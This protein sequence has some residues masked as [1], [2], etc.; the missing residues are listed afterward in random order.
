MAS[1]TSNSRT[2]RAKKTP[3]PASGPIDFSWEL[4]KAINAVAKVQAAFNPAVEDCKKLVA[5]TFQDLEQR[6]AHK[7]KEMDLLDEDYE[8]KKKSRKLQL[9]HEL[10]AFGLEEATKLIEAQKK[11]VVAE[12]E[13]AKTLKEIAE[14]R[15]DQEMTKAQILQAEKEKYSK[16]LEIFKTTTLLEH[17]SA[18]AEVNAKNEQHNEHIKVLK[19]RI[20]AQQS[21]IDKQRELTKHVSATHATP[22]PYYPPP[23]NNSGR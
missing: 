22:Q 15:K 23:Q 7:R 11:K 10:N 1:S 4:T 12:D 20:V 5:D 16:E 8:M 19:E 17:K 6:V 9:E 21:E 2:E 18:L 14:L 3:K 13:Y